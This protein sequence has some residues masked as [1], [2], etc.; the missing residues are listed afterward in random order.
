MLNARRWGAKMEGS[1]YLWVHEKEMEDFASSESG[2]VDEGPLLQRDCGSEELF[3][4]SWDQRRAHPLLD[5]G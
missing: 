4:Q 5:K 3:L 1:K 2:K